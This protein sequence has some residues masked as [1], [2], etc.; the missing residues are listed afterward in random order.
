M[1]NRELLI[2]LFC[3]GVVLF[4][5]LIQDKTASPPPAGLGNKPAGKALIQKIVKKGEHTEKELEKTLE[6][7]FN[8]YPDSI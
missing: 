1:M 8:T 2:V 6:K 4:L 3:I 5:Y 7:A